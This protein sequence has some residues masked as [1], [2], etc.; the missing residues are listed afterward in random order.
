MDAAII[1]QHIVHLEEG[2]LCS[3]VGVESNE[4]IAQGVPGLPIA[5]DVT[6]CYLSKLGENDL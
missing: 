6:G 1:N 3:L 4:S 2:I 5:N